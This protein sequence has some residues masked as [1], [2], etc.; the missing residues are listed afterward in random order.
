M[1]QAS[2]STPLSGAIASFTASP[3]RI[4]CWFDGIW[5]AAT[6]RSERELVCKAPLQSFGTPSLSVVDMYAQR[7]F[8]TN[9]TQTGGF[10]SFTVR[11][12]EVVDVVL[13]SVGN[14]MRN[15]VAD[16]STLVDFFGRNLIAGYGFCRCAHLPSLEPGYIPR[17]SDESGRKANVIFRRHH[18]RQR[19][20]PRSDTAFTP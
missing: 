16:S 3:I 11:K 17:F 15:T 9:A 13:P 1:I 6:L 20:C 7:M 12:D 5:V 2:S 8:P 18:P 4:G 10:T 19:R 14:A